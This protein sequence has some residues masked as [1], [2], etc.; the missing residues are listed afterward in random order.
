M[1][2]E[3]F[4]P[5]FLR[6][7][8]EILES[9]LKD[10]FVDEDKMYNCVIWV[11][12]YTGHPTEELAIYDFDDTDEDGIEYAGPDAIISKNILRK[13]GENLSDFKTRA[14]GILIDYF[15]ESYDDMK[16]FQEGLV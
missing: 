14:E 11:S 16:A 8:F 13:K 4:S 15:R 9:E 10:S 2:S 12:C 6:I 3:R 7:F 1:K 5:F